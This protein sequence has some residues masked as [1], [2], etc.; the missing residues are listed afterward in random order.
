MLTFP[1]EPRAN[2]VDIAGRPRVDA[3]FSSTGPAMHVFALLAD[4][5]PD[6][7]T[8]PLSH[9][10]LNLPGDRLGAPTAVLLDDLA[11][12]FRAGHRIQ[13]QISSSDFPWYIVHPGTAENPWL[14]TLVERNRQS[15]QVGGGAG[16]PRLTLPVLPTPPDALACAA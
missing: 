15:V 13:V 4:V 2:P 8:R 3:T 5:E 10:A 11:Y 7:T 12:R 9:A 16:A 6:G 14:A 1:T